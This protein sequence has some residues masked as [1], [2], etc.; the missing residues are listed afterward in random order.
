MYYEGRR[1][2]YRY[3]HA[4]A[5]SE[6]DRT[7]CRE[8]SYAAGEIETYLVKE[9]TMAGSVKYSGEGAVLLSLT[10]GK[11]YHFYTIPIADGQ[12]I[13]IMAYRK[14]TRRALQELAEGEGGTVPFVGLIT[15]PQMEISLRWYEGIPGFK[16]ENLVQEYVLKEIDLTGQKNLMIIGGIILF[17]ALLLY[18]QSG[19]IRKRILEPE[20]F[21]KVERL[22][23]RSYNK[24]NELEIER[25]RLQLYRKR[26]KALMG[27]C[28]A[29]MGCLPLGI[30]ITADCGSGGFIKERKIEEIHIGKE[31]NCHG[32][33]NNR[34]KR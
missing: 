22:Y 5:L 32:H 24:E 20:R 2:F 17:I 31:R 21:D 23:T 3:H 11:E 10:G 1:C 19:G 13:Q 12:Y 30:Y 27:W 9:I 28:I 4:L 25:D 6:L 34:I 7:A 29:A 16:L 8:G 33:K 26:K 14:E 15:K 18:A